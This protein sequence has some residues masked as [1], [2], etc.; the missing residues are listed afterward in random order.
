MSLTIYREKLI[1]NIIIMSKDTIVVEIST[2]FSSYVLFNFGCNSSEYLIRLK[3][4]V[5]QR[6]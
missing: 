4:G 3:F 5:L 6:F 2:I 1:L